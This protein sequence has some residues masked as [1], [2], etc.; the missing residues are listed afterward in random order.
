MKSEELKSKIQFESHDV[1]HNLTIIIGKLEVR[2]VVL[3]DRHQ[4]EAHQ[5]SGRALDEIKERIREMIM[6]HI[7][8]DQRRELYDALM[9]LFNAAPMDYSAMAAARE[10]ILHA[11]KRQ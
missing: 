2:A 3:H 7:Y 5:N 8:D 1:G 4:I 10:K 6:R 11:A 9:E